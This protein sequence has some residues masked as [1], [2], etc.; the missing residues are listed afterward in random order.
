MQE[1]LTLLRQ[2][3][4]DGMTMILATHEMQFAKE[5]ASKVYFLADGEVHESGSPAEFFGNPQKARTRSFLKRVL[6]S[7]KLIMS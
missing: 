6:G 1:V 3:A 7:D 4:E 5:V 2:L